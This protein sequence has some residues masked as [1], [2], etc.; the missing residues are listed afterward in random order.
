MDPEL[1]EDEQIAKDVAKVKKA[2]EKRD[3]QRLIQLVLSSPL[4]EGEVSK[5]DGTRSIESFKKVNTD[6]QSRIIIN[7]AIDAVK[8]DARSREFL[9]KYG[10]FEPVREQSLTMETPIIIDDMTEFTDEGGT[11][12]QDESVSDSGIILYD[13]GTVD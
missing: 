3:M 12:G 7:T 2:N 5:V 10:G 9:F 4:Y 6:V 11:E 1:T 8:G 13:D